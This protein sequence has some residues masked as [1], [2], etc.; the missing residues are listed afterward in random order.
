MPEPLKGVV[1]FLSITGWRLG[2]AIGLQWGNVDLKSGTLRLESYQTRG[3]DV[4]IYHYAEDPEL[5]AV[6]AERRV[7]TQAFDH[8]H[9][10][11]TPWVFWSEGSDGAAKPNE[12]H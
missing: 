10:T 2:E 12:L 9:A 11:I 5:K 1:R 8:E 3:K 6:I 4:R 7:A